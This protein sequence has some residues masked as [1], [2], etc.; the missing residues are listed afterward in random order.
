MPATSLLFLADVSLHMAAWLGGLHTLF[1]LE[2]SLTYILSNPLSTFSYT[3]L[4]KMKSQQRR[5]HLPHLN[6]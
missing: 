4:D 6:I 5:D 2:H 3:I 1:E